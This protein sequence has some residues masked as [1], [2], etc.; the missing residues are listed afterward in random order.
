VLAFG[1]APSVPPYLPVGAG[2]VVAAA[3][4]YFLPRWAADGAFQSGH[5]F[6]LVFGAT[7]GSMMAGFV[8]F[9]GGPSKDLYF[10]IVVDVMAV[11]FLI[12]LGWRVHRRG[13]R[14]GAESKWRLS[15]GDE[16]IAKEQIAQ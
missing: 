14:Q 7:F 5:R 10:K 12:V 1:I 2:L 6:A 9:L 8:R 13:N 4:L 3:G 11:I 15:I 16:A